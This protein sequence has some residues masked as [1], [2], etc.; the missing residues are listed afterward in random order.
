MPLLVDMKIHFYS[1][2][3]LYGETYVHHDF[4]SHMSM[5]P[6][7]YRCWHPYK[8]THLYEAFFPILAAFE[9]SSLAH[10]ALVYI[11]SPKGTPHGEGS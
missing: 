8:R 11:P 2:R 5:L 6:C 4:H 1:M 9:Y 7:M 3:F 10:D